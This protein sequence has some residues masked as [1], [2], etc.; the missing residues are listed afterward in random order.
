MHNPFPHTVVTCTDLTPPT[1]GNLSTTSLNYQGIATYSCDPGYVLTGN[2]GSAVR[3]CQTT[4]QWSGEA[5]TCPRELAMVGGSNGD[6][7][8]I[9]TVVDCGPLAITNGAVDTSSGTTFMMTATYT[10]NTG[11]NIVG[12]ESRICGASGVWS[13]T[14]PVCESMLIPCNACGLPRFPIV[15]LPSSSEL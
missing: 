9:T 12:S 10:C 13:P 1:N 11:Y 8:Y 7:D 14:A 4:S 5:P 2:S 15:L 3:T 6:Q